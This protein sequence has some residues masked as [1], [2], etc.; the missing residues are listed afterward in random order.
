[1]RPR[2]VDFTRVAT[3][4]SVF[5]TPINSTCFLYLFIGVFGFARVLFQT[6]SDFNT[7]DFGAFFFF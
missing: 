4:P 3:T 1:M 5:S 6:R 7:L 2:L